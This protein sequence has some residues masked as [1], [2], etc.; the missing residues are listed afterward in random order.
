MSKSSILHAGA[1]SLAAVALAGTLAGC[2]SHPP[3]RAV[4]TASSSVTPDSGSSA[5]GS[6]DGSTPSDGANEA[7]SGGGTGSSA[8]AGD[9]GTG[10]QS[11]GGVQTESA[12]PPVPET[13]G[14]E[15]PEARVKSQPYLSLPS[16]PVGVSG[17]GET[18]DAG[19]TSPTQCVSVQYRGDQIP[20]GMRVT[21]TAVI[22]PAGVFT[23]RGSCGGYPACESS[24]FAF[25]AA[26][27]VCNVLT[28][29]TGSDGKEATF[30]T[31]G[32]VWCGTASADQCAAYTQKALQ[33]S[34]RI[35]GTAT[36]T[37][38]ES[39]PASSD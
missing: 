17:G 23:I 38:P 12:P 37:Q 5:G 6:T 27:A 24:G 14:P 4:A 39:T 28:E 11:D 36:L 26:Q 7:A 1:M 22:S 33:D 15:H 8:D 16:P 34:R 3:G 2:G 13:S 18:D 32:R 10:T 25:T 35:D 21:V 9:H 29:A 30:S 19:N 31:E 20:D